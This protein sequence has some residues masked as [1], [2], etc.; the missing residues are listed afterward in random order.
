MNLLIVLD[1]ATHLLRNR[2][3]RTNLSQFHTKEIAARNQIRLLLK[4]LGTQLCGPRIRRKR[5]VQHFIRRHKP[6]PI[7]AG[8]KH[9]TRIRIDPA[10]KVIAVRL[11]TIRE[12]LNLIKQARGD[13]FYFGDHISVA[14]Q[15]QTDTC[16]NASVT[17]LLDNVR[18]ILT[19]LT[20]DRFRLL[21]SQRERLNPME[22]VQSLLRR[23]MQHHPLRNIV[24]P[25]QN[26]VDIQL[27]AKV[28][29]LFS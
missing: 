23:T 12:T 8:L 25:T 21:R 2:I 26:L 4:P 10:N 1:D 11:K 15:S 16:L 20:D 29:S 22:M 7:L 17:N 19:G 6:M 18:S 9:V 28:A 3:R 24:A 14:T 13:S 5:K 27:Y